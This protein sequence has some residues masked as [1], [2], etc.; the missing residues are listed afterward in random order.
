MPHANNPRTETLAPRS[1]E[2][3]DIGQWIRQQREKAGLGQ[4]EVSR[5]LGKNQSFMYRVERGEQRLDLVQFFDLLQ[6]LG[7]DK[8]LTIEQLLT[9]IRRDAKD[10][11]TTIPE[12]P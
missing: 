11:P 6:I 10:K 2:Y 1:A 8:A 5:A 12:K 4:R 9:A 3:Q 7:L